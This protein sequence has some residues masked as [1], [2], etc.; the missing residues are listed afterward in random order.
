MTDGIDGMIARSRTRARIRTNPS[1][2]P[3]VVPMSAP[4]RPPGHP[5]T[6]IDDGTDQLGRTDRLQVMTTPPAAMAAAAESTH[7]RV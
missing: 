2:H 5:V 4:T 7:I 3:G 1:T 6:A